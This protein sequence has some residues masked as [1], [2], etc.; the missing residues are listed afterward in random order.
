MKSPPVKITVTLD[1]P[2]AWHLAQFLKRVSFTTCERHADPTNPEEPHYM[3]TALE[4]VRAALA[5]Q[6]VAP[7]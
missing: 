5:E 1:E 3:L 4:T 7:R 6:G 2:H